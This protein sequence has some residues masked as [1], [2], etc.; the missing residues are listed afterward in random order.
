M[1]DDIDGIKKSFE[2]AEKKRDAAQR[3][4][5]GPKREKRKRRSSSSTG[6]DDP[7]LEDSNSVGVD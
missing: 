6:T 1:K 2:K 7:N 4:N 5:R 3:K